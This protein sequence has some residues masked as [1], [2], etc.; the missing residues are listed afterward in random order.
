MER[1]L[2][3]TA[4]AALRVGFFGAIGGAIGLAIIDRSVR[5]AERFRQF[6]VIWTG[7]AVVEF[8]RHMLERP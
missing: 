3:E 7:V 6:L 5:L 1:D 4:L 8:L 2:V